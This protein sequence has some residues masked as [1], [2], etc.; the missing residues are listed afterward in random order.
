M[1]YY[2]FESTSA[3][4]KIKNIEDKIR[5]YVSDL[6]IAGEMTAPSSARSLEYLIT[7]AKEKKYSTVVAVGGIRHITWIANKLA[8]SKIVLG[9]IPVGTFPDLNQ[10]L[11]ISN[12]QDAANALK[13]RRY[14][15]TQL[16][17]IEPG[18][19]VF[20]TACL[21][22]INNQTNSSIVFPKFTIDSFYGSITVKLSSDQHLVFEI[23]SRQ[24]RSLLNLFKKKV[25]S[26]DINTSVFYEIKG[27]IITNP[28]SPLFIDGEEITH[29]PVFVSLHSKKLKMIV[30]KKSA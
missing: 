25:K 22:K 12:W 26:S 11:N 3:N 21:V 9:I 24:N 8:G 4:N 6:G 23:S 30:S 1:Y 17:V 7:Q 15:E 18:A 19:H 29:T 27:Q 28:T 13:S 16:G 10:L 5:D 14:I 2:I 20:L